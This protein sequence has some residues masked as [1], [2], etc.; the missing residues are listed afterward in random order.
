MKNVNINSILATTF[1]VNFCF[2]FRLARS[3]YSCVW[4]IL[5][6]NFLQNVNQHEYQQSA[7]KGFCNI[8]YYTEALKQ[9]LAQ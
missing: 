9:S 3:T 7:T 6:N 5:S 1:R 8:G 4:F 2:L